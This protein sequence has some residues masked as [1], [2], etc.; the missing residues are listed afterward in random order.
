MPFDYQ[1]ARET[2]LKIIAKYGA[3]GSVVKKGTTGGFDSKG[4]SKADV[5]DSTIYGTVT[6]LVQYKTSEI[7]GS[8]I[9]VGDAW[10]FF[11]SNTPPAIEMQTTINGKTF[12]IIDIVK[13]SSVDDINI[14]Q[15][16]QLRK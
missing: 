2:A 7:D 5:P 11:H 8:K 14:Y 16:L 13:L 10:V 4:D 6:P 9:Q 1:K 12:R 15:K 3:P